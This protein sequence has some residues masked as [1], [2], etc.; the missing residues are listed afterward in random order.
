MRIAVTTDD[1]INTS[2]PLD[3]AKG[4]MIYDIEN[5]DIIN[6]FYRLVYSPNIVMIQ[7]EIFWNRGKKIYFRKH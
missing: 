3:R 2:Y 7:T 6:Q 5:G 1:K 4:F